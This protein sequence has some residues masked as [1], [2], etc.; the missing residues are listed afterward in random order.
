MSPKI[1]LPSL[2]FL[3]R[4]MLKYANRA[5]IKLVIRSQSFELTHIQIKTT[6]R[7]GFSTFKHTT[8]D[9]T[10]IKE[11]KFALD[12]I[13][14]FVSVVDGSQE[15]DQGQVYVEVSLELNGVIV[16]QL[17]AGLVYTLKGLTWPQTEIADVRP[18]GGFLRSVF[19]DA[20]TTGD[21]IDLDQDPNIIWKVI[22]ILINFITDGTSADRRII[23][24]MESG[25]GYF[26]E[27]VAPI[28]QPASQDWNYNFMIGA[29]DS[30][31]AIDDRVMVNLPQEIFIQGEGNITSEVV[32]LKAGDEFGDVIFM[33]EEYKGSWNV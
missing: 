13:P 15:N 3:T 32:N 2:P 11:E 8:S 28:V 14:I 29:T 20:I 27:L 17:C 9:D 7:D 25:D 6:T 22:G 4:E 23:L 1:K 24:F 16:H 33:V 12:N 10:E 5:G 21:D 30:A 31:A 18:N 19:S 26:Y